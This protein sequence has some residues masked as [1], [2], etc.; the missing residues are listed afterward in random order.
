MANRCQDA[1]QS[2]DKCHRGE[3]NRDSEGN[4]ANGLSFILTHEFERILEE[5]SED[6]EENSWN[7]KKVIINI[8]NCNLNH[9]ADTQI[10]WAYDY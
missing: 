6:V 7:L 8:W 9:L 5:S 10:M 4:I 1:Q 3:N 2:Y